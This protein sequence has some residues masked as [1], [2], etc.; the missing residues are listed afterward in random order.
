MNDGLFIGVGE[1]GRGLGD[2]SRSGKTETSCAATAHCGVEDF[3]IGEITIGDGEKEEHFFV[4]F[5]LGKFD[6]ISNGISLQ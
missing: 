6:L 5:R 1:R 2:S 3:G 4:D